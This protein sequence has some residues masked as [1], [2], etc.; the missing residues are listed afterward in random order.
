MV[1]KLLLVISVVLVSTLFLPS[2]TYSGNKYYV[3]SY[4]VDVT[5]N[6][7]ILRPELLTRKYFLAVNNSTIFNVKISS[8]PM[9]TTDKGGI[10]LNK[11]LDADI[12]GGWHEDVYFVSLSTWYAV[13]DSTGYPGGTAIIK[14]TEKE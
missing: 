2:I 5:S 14:V 7:V 3:L 9:K 13:I 11:A 12:A 10:P 6:S 4:D 1:K 8:W